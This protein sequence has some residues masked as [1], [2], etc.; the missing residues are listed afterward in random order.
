M[1]SASRELQKTIYNALVADAAVGALVGNRIYDRMPSDGEYPC[2]TFG[3]AD[4]ITDDADCIDGEEHSAQID[5]WSRDQ[6]RMGPCKDIVA[7][8]K[9]ALHDANLTIADPFALVFIRVVGTRVFSD[10][11]GITSHGV[12][13]VQAMI[14]T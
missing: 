14:E 6:G 4:E 3:P 13:T 10:S 5:V 9:T 11:D 2:I 8:A 1:A 12:V 7:A